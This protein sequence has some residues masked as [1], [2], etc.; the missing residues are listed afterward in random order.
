LLDDGDLLGAVVFENGA[1]PVDLYA[2]F[3][4]GF[5]GAGFDGFPEGVRGAFGDDGEGDVVSGE[6]GCGEGEGEEGEQGFFHL[7]EWERKE[8]NGE[9]R[10]RAEGFRWGG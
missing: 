4:G 3:L 10:K 2:G 6:G 5:A 1:A 7:G 8:G 9:G